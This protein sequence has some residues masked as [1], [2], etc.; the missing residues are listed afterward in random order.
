MPNLLTKE[1][2][3]INLPKSCPNIHSITL[4][5]HLNEKFDKLGNLDLQNLNDY[6][7][8][9]LSVCDLEKLVKQDVVSMIV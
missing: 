5:N 8:K 2:F 9:K 6:D 4:E 7:L 1:D 3:H